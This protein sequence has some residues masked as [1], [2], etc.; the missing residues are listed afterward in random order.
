M[1]EKYENLCCQ[2]TIYIQVKMSPWHVRETLSVP[3][4][5]THKHGCKTYIKHDFYLS[6]ILM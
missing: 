3:G 5:E 4:G 1:D 2:V 6:Q